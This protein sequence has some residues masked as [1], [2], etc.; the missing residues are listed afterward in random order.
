MAFLILPFSG[1][2]DY[3]EKKYQVFI[4]STYTDLERERELVTR[5][6]FEAGHIPVGMEAF[7]A[8]ARS[9][10]DFIRRMILSTDYYVVILGGRYGSTD[11]DGLSFTHKEYLLAKELGKPVLVFFRREIDKLDAKLRDDDLTKILAFHGEACHGTLAKPWSNEADLLIAL[12]ASLNNAIL[13]FPAYGWIRGDRVASESQLLELADLRQENAKLRDKLQSITETETTMRDEKFAE[14]FSSP[15]VLKGKYHCPASSHSRAGTRSW[16]EK[17]LI[18]AIW[19]AVADQF[20]VAK[21]REAALKLIAERMI[22]PA[23]STYS[24]RRLD[25]DTASRLE[26]AFHGLGLISLKDNTSTEG[27]WFTWW[28]AT[29]LGLKVAR[30]ALLKDVF[31]PRE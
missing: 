26:V 31:E 1:R 14:L 9:Q 13:D 6:V 12:P 7:P 29:P 16:E 19:F 3:M 4:S 8:A 11:E 17:K 5:Q 28:K 15:I 10:W 24:V 22:L 18:S 23:A 21:T 2:D 27:K 30:E 25:S 20:R